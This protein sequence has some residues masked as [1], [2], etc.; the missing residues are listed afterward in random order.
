M[1]LPLSTFVAFLSRRGLS[2]KS[3]IIYGGIVRTFFRG[4]GLTTKDITKPVLDAYV[5]GMPLSRR[6]QFRYGWQRFCEFARGEGVELPGFDPG[7]AAS[8]HYPVLVEHLPPLV[9]W[10]AAL[11]K[12][13]YVQ[14]RHVFYEP[15]L[16]LEGWPRPGAC[17]IQM[18]AKMTQR[19]GR[20][21]TLS[22]EE[23][24]GRPHVEA[25]IDWGH[26]ELPR[27]ADAPFIP[28]MPGS[29][30]ALSAT[31]LRAIVAAGVPAITPD[32]SVAVD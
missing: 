15:D 2:E 20:R 7:A 12:L 5:A 21:V 29:T 30:T 23:A 14:L 17:S 32:G 1:D 26:P 28:V 27:K 22:M 4:T 13:P 8:Y 19:N 24:I 31:A 6:P 25:I 11:A 10:G 3:Q 16:Q 9:R 18:P